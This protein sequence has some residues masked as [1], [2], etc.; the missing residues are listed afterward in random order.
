MLD[1]PIICELCPCN[2]QYLSMSLP[3]QPLRSVLPGR[4]YFMASQHSV[5]DLLCT[6]SCLLPHCD[7]SGRMPAVGAELV[8]ACSI[9]LAT[10]RRIRDRSVFSYCDQAA[11]PLRYRLAVHQRSSGI[12][13]PCRRASPAAAQRR[14]DLRHQ[15][16]ARNPAAQLLPFTTAGGAA[17]WRP[18]TW[19]AAA[20]AMCWECAAAA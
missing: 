1:P 18:A 5:K 6:R 12:R 20:P 11:S 4:Q 17:R 15:A 10:C 16:A 13:V 9:P 7:V 19:S 2:A 8:L 3:S 14:L